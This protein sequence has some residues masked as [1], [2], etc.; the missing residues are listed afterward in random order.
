MA[1]RVADAKARASAE[2]DR[3]LVRVIGGA[4]AEKADLD[5][6]QVA[7]GA[8]YDTLSEANGTEDNRRF[9]DDDRADFYVLAIEMTAIG[10]PEHSGWPFRSD[11]R[12][13]VA[14]ALRRRLGRG[15]GPWTHL[16][17]IIPS[18]LAKDLGV[19]RHCLAQLE[20]DPYLRK[21]ALDW[22]NECVM[23][24]PGQNDVATLEAFLAPLGLE[25]AWNPRTSI[26][27]DA[28]RWPLLA[29]MEP[30]LVVDPRLALADPRPVGLLRAMLED[31][32]DVVDH[33]SARRVIAWLV[34]DGHRREIA[35][36]LSEK[37]APV[38]RRAAFVESHRAALATTDTCA[39]DHCRAVGVARACLTTS[40]LDEGEVR[41]AIGEAATGLSDAYASWT[42]LAEGY[43]LG[44]SYFAPDEID[45][46]PFIGRARWQRDSSRSPWRR[47]PFGAR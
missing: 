38:A 19:A 25:D 24:Y 8:L 1:A 7:F 37:R 14:P 43:I 40:M 41:F 6:A 20:R 13:M 16:A 5:R 11:I 28:E 17:C 29:S 47:V 2:I 23:D 4:G 31:S 10:H 45:Y 30:S 46:S 44:A 42:E 33:A 39:W 27:T 12:G 36:V 22:V 9:A 3:V 18:L 21:L 26:M 32:W 35:E 15:G 34:R